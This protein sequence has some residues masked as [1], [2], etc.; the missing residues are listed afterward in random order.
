M[1]VWGLDFETGGV[2]PGRHAPVSIGLALTEGVEVLGE[3]EWIIG[4]VKKREY[5]VAALSISGIKWGQI[6]EALPLENVLGLVRDVVTGMGGQHWHVVSHNSSFDQA[7][8]SDCKFLCGKWGSGKFADRVFHP[9]P[10]IFCGPW[11]CTMRMARGLL[12]LHDYKLDTVL[13]DL[14]LERSGK[15]HGAAEDARLAAQAWSILR[16]MQ[17]Q[18]ET[19]VR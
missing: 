10:E 7:F 15:L 9:F 3:W 11:H 4:Q 6:K 17:I 19:D 1:K 14:G 8:Y 16:T 18:L 12:Q 2:E 5:D 13:A